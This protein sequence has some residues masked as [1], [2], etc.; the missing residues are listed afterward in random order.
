LKGNQ[1]AMSTVT[2]II[3]GTGSA[4]AA[5]QVPLPLPCPLPLVRCPLLLSQ[6]YHYQGVLIG[7]VS[8][9]WGWDSVFW[10]L[11]VWRPLVEV[12]DMLHVDVLMF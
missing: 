6:R 3:D 12:T 7:W 11:M 4:G 8:D 9:R 1:K 2:G 5:L 10:M